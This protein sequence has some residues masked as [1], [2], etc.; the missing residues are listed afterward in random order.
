MRRLTQSS[1]RWFVTILR[2]LWTNFA[3][4]EAVLLSPSWSWNHPSLF[5]PRLNL[6][7]S[8][9]SPRRSQLQFR[10]RFQRQLRLR[11]QFRFWFRPQL[12]FPNWCR[13]FRHIILGRT[14]RPNRAGVP[15]G[16]FTIT[17]EAGHT[18]IVATKSHTNKAAPSCECEKLNSVS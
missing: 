9:K 8:P 4:K 10:Y 18:H 6:L 12:R 14:T 2:S 15:G 16:L 3:T 1:S 17:G 5:Q 11:I 7:R 13:C